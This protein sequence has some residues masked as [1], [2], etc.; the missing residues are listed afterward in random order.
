MASATVPTAAPGAATRPDRGERLW[1]VDVLRTL[2][3]VLMV[4]YHAGY[5]VDL[6]AP[7]VGLDPFSGG[8]R[9]LQV[10]T[11]STFLG[12]VGL[13]F[14]ISDQRHRARGRRGRALW[15]AHV[16]RGLQVAA[17]ALLVS[18]A[19]LVALGPG[20]A[21]R[22]GILHLIA[23]LMLVV[24]PAAARLGPA[25][26]VLGAVVIAVGLLAVKPVGT[27]VPGLL[28][29]GFDPGDPGVDWYPLLPWGGCALVGLGLAALLY[30]GGERGPLVRRLL[31]P[32]PRRARLAGAPGRHSL[33]IYLVH[34]PVL[35]A[36]VA[37]VLLLAGVE[38]EDP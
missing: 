9:A 3:I 13:S 7:S 32:E 12:V 26:L 4:T 28:V 31:P 8:W 17:A 18:I 2:G 11:G 10:V 36:L 38:V 25:N 19:T 24:L 6:L 14:W 27:D 16:P 33:P 30:P 29:L 22:F 21:V 1:E 37:G 34:Q 35:I 23:L 20:D 15:R 5:D